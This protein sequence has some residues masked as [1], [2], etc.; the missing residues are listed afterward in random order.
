MRTGRCETFAECMERVGERRA[1]LRALVDPLGVGARVDRHASVEPRGRSSG[2]S[3]RRTTGAT[4]STSATSSGATTP[5]ACTCTSAST[6]RT[7]RSAC[8]ARSATIC[9]SCSRVSASSPFVEGVLHV[10]ALRPHAGVHADVPALRDPR[11]VRRLGRLGGATSG[12]STRR[13]RSPSTR[14]SG[15]ASARTLRFRRSRSASAT[16]SRT[17][18]EAASLV[19][20]IYSLDGADRAR[21]RRGRAAAVL[22]APAAR[23]E[24]LARDPS[25][26]VG[27]ADRLRAGRVDSGSRAHRAA[28]RVG[29]TRSPTS[30][31]RR[32]GSPF[33]SGTRPSG[34]SHA[35]EEGASMEE[36]FTEQV[37]AG[38]RVSG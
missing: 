7:G 30:S 4:T 12:S 24:S 26:A 22:A 1:Q 2:S 37:R 15:G 8:A 5:S 32:S 29:A 38:E 6:A 36:I 16:R 13:D 19:A 31:A 17:L 14:S 11:L 28:H 9:R 25:R 20:L 21:P 34:R 27:R 23:G 18:A 35:H 3:T 33:P 10:P